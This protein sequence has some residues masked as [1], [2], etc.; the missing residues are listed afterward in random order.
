MCSEELLA[1]STGR[2]NLVKSRVRCEVHCHFYWCC[3]VMLFLFSNG[4]NV[5]KLNAGNS[6]TRISGRFCKNIISILNYIN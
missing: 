5:Y 1:G 4:S 3:I 2:E 6:F